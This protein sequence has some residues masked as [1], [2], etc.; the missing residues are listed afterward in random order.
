MAITHRVYLSQPLNGRFRRKWQMPDIV[1][2]DSV[3][4]ITA[5][6]YNPAIV[7]PDHENERLRFLGDANIWVSNI[8]PHGAGSP[9]FGVEFAI[10]V[11]FPN[12]LFVV[13]DITVLDPPEGVFHI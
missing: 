6:E 4:V 2:S 10:N 12:P 13:F 3:V 9:N 8:S 11:D 1:N 5:T 7:P